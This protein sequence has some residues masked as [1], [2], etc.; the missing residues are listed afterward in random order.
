[1]EKLLFPSL[2]SSV[3]TFVHQYADTSSEMKL[4]MFLTLPKPD[5]AV[6]FTHVVELPKFPKSVAIEIR[7]AH[8]ENPNVKDTD[9]VKARKSLEEKKSADVNE[10]VMMTAKGIT[11]GT[12]SN[13]FVINSNGVVITAPDDQILPGTIRNIVLSI[14]QKAGTPLEL[15]LPQISD[16]SH[17]KSVFL[18]SSSRLILPVEKVICPEEDP[19]KE[20]HFSISETTLQ[21]QELLWKE[22]QTRSRKLF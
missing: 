12:Q 19:P 5:T 16:I 1:M 7:N 15:K 10:V 6:L 18:T 13:C 17:W 11:E 20:Y 8:R 9:W 22:L 21:L 14:C 3:Q 4:T 2:Q